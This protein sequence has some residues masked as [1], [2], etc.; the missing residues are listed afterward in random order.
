MTPTQQGQAARQAG[1]PIHD[2]PFVRDTAEWVAWREGWQAAPCVF[3]GGD[4]KAFNA[5]ARL[6]GGKC[7]ACGGDGI[8]KPLLLAQAGEK[9]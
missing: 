5:Q 6:E 3:C 4:G 8:Q 9:E 2:C 1:R 7:A